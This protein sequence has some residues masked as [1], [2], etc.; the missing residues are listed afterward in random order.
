MEMNIKMGIIRKL[1]LPPTIYKNLHI[2]AEFKEELHIIYIRACNDLAKKSGE[3]PFVAT[4]DVIFDV[5]ETRPL[6]WCT[7][8]IV[9]MEKHVA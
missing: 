9:M 1:Q 3:L 7:P 5:L 2:F 4:D 8:D 6:E